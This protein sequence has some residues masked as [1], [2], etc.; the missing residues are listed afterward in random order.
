[1]LIDTG[2]GAAAPF[3]A[4]GGLLA[5]LEAANISAD[6]IDV[7]VFTH[8][9]LDHVLGAVDGNGVLV[10]PNATYLMAKGEH[11]FWTSDERLAQI[12]PDQAAAEGAAGAFLSILPA[13]QPRLELVDENAGEEFLPGLR[14]L[15]TYGHTPGHSSV[16]VASGGERL[17]VAGDAFVH[18]LHV[19]HPDW[20]FSAD[21]LFGQGD[22]SRRGLLDLAAGDEVLVQA[23]HL[24]FPGLGRVVADGDG[25][26]WEP[27][28][29]Q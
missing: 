11:D 12:F 14:L 21:T 26:R 22:I 15:P 8:A 25:Y 10:F 9:H 1:V 23:Y 2:L 13:L 4:T 27:A 3:P 20:N 19:A 5:S 6:D 28:A 7:V 16:V 29:E 24:P 17:I 18:P